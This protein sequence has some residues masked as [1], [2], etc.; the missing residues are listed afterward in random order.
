MKNY[1]L[2]VTFCAG[3]DDVED[4]DRGL[5][6]LSS[7]ENITEEEMKNIFRKV[8]KLLD[9]F[10]DNY[11]KF[12]ISYEQGVNIDTLISGV[13]IYTGGKAKYIKSGCNSL[14]DI[15]SY[16]QIEQWY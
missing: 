11:D 4:T 16:Y 9:C 2:N 7:N 13:E 3:S 12:P 6:L 14:S 10:D 15:D 8:N 1:L 5:Y